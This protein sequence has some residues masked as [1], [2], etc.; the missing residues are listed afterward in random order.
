MIKAP[1]IGFFSLIL[2]VTAPADAQSMFRADQAHSGVFPGPAPRQFHRVKWKFATG[3]RI[4]SS[5]VFADNVIYF[6]GDDGNVY[7]V[8]P[9]TGAQLW[10]YSTGGPV[11]ATPAVVDGTV[12]VGSYDGKFYALE[13]KTGLTK[14][15]FATEGERRFEAKGLNG[16][17]PKN[18]TMADPYDVFLSS[19]VVVQDTVYFGSGDGNLYAVDT[20]SG[21]LRWRFKTGDVIHASP[22][23]NEGLIYFGSWDSYFYAVDAISG[24]ERWRFHGGEDALV[25]NQVGFQSSPVVAGGVVYTGCRDSNV[26]ALDAFTGKEKWRFNNEMSWVNTAPAVSNGKIFFAT[27][28]SSLYHVAD[29]ATGKSVVK[30]Q[31]KAYMFSSPAVVGDVVLIGVLNGT[32]EARDINSG[33]LL[34]D[35]KIEKS[36]QNKGWV[37]TSDRKFNGPLLFQSLWREA[38]TLATEKQFAI[39]GIFSSPLVVNGTVYF[40]STDGYLYA[41]D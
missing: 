15:K 17:Q 32:L 16:L 22:A 23:Y 26:Y 8:N 4:V 9:D 14:W 2:F 11:P 24:K 20:A 13:A 31:S 6:G 7:A 25:H 34:W 30:Q 27:S 41:I 3:D 10:K 29:A 19:P 5:P 39:G 1:L 18:Q 36:K 38:P 28:D 21:D 37:L 12:Y 33:E 40:G 35:Y